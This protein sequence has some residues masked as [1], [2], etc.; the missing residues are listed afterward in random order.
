MSRIISQKFSSVMSE[1]GLDVSMLYSIIRCLTV[2]RETTSSVTYFDCVKP[3]CNKVFQ[4]FLGNNELSSSSS[5]PSLRM[6]NSAG[7]HSPP[8]YP[9]CCCQSCLNP[10]V[11]TQCHSLLLH[12][13]SPRFFRSSPLTF[14]FRC[15]CQGNSW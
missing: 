8:R 9:V 11:E 2:L 6:E 3:A 1:N 5:F 15:P 10:R 7:N 14:P 13:P 4:L 12:S